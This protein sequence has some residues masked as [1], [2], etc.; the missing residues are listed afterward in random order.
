MAR[1]GAS[2]KAWL[3]FALGAAS[4]YAVMFNRVAAGQMFPQLMAEFNTTGVGVAALSSIY[5]YTYAIM[6]VPAGALADTLGPRKSLSS[7]LLLGGLAWILFGSAKSIAV[8]S[9]ARMVAG[10]GLAN[11]FLSLLKSIQI[12]FPASNYGTLTGIS[13]FFGNLGVATA[14]FPFVI[15]V[16]S[17]GWRASSTI[18]GTATLALAALVWLLVRDDGPNNV[19]MPRPGLRTI[20]RVSLEGLWEIIRRP[21]SLPP[22]FGFMM[23]FGGLMA[24]TGLWG[25]PFL[26]QVHG[27]SQSTSGSLLV[28]TTAGAALAAVLVG[29][30]TDRSGRPRMMFILLAMFQVAGWLIIIWTSWRAGLPG[31]VPAIVVALL[32]MGVSNSSFLP[33]FVV[34]RSANRPE[35]SSL[36]QGLNNGSGFIGAILSQA[37]VSA[38]MDAGWQGEYFTE[39]VRFYSASTYRAGFFICL[40]AVLVAVL[41]GL[42]MPKDR[43]R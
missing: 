39:G 27:L 42:L 15:L 41:C 14:M 7:G 36:A 11:I 9:V 43:P 29:W 37:V 4:H 26:M 8:A 24:F 20:L 16:G 34:M 33:A 35:I 19:D 10:F 38:V 23:V 21:A 31:N 13:T 18:V 40:A 32:L 30:L 17:A 6:Q 3:I 25:V 1:T 5:Y 22:F 12:W 28:I 2:A